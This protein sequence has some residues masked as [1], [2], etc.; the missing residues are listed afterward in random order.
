MRATAYGIRS[1]LHFLIV[2]AGEVARRD[3]W[4]SRK[5]EEVR[6]RTVKGLEPEI[7]R[8]IDQHKSDVDALEAQQHVSVH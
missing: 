5:T 4:I 8:I 1:G 7:Q 2:A 3:R 6:E